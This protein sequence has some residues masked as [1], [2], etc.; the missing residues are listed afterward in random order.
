[1]NFKD[2]T[3]KNFMSIGNQT[4]AIDLTRADI[5]LVLGE[6]LD[7]GGN[8]SRNGTGKSTF[9][10][11]LSYVWYGQALSNIKKDNL[12][13]YINK[14]N[15]LVTHSFI[16]DNVNYRIER[17]RKPNVLKLY[18]NDQSI[19]TA[20]TDDAQGDSRET[21]KIL[22]ELIGMS[23]DMFKQVIALNTY[24][25]PFLSMRANDQRVIIEQLLGITILSEKAEALKEQIK[26]TK[27]NI[28]QATADIEAI[29][30]SNESIQKSIDSL[31]LRQTA[32]ASQQT[33]TSE[34]IGSAI[35]ELEG[36]DIDAEI[37]AHAELKVFLEQ[38]A[39]RNS[40]TK[41]QATLQAA[42]SQATKTV[43]KYVAELDTL[44]D[45]KCPACEQ[46]LH[47][48][49]HDEML[50]TVSAN[51]SDSQKY[52]EKVSADHTKIS[53]EINELG[54]IT[55][56]PETYYDSVE[57]AYTH[58]NNLQTLEAQLI[59]KSEEIDPYQEQIDELKV[60]ALQELN[61]DA[62][63]QFTL[64]KDHQDFLL[65][66][67]TNKDSFIRKKII[68]QNL[69]YLNNRMMHY[70]IQL[71]LPHTVVFQNDLSVD[72]SQLGQDLDFHN[73]SRGEMNRVILATSFSFRDVWESLYQ[74]VNLLYVDEMLDSGLDVSG[75]EN[76]LVI[77]KTIARER[78]K[79][80]FLISHK[81]ELV[82]RVNNIL[83]VVK[84][85]SFTSFD[86][87]LVVG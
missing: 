57:Q 56:R 3:I 2:L 52:F 36:V 45:K 38:T 13:N 37:Q 44:S 76:A 22:D 14:K 20:E 39:K 47:E 68:D 82:G 75:A 33:N 55:R 34:R 30:R 25:E 46:D 86:D 6:N 7:Q 21:Q 84:E 31:Q 1:M 77:L 12:I 16:K 48:H 78:K 58:Q 50:A 54:T 9:G 35:I 69:S 29:K 70:L 42:L 32:W 8:G 53:N 28:F 83:R 15:M 87:S 27:D 43:S 61:W 62:I 66:L 40:L 80:I 63:N 71:G 59:S 26:Q 10:N 60:T 17:G 81:E 85:N 64:L 18:V 51:I 67:L 5:T 74:S 65:K 24:S 19:A 23:H 73:L 11:A 79:N 41:E 4:Q 49:K 72:I